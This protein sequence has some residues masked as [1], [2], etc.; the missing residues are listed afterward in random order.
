M[1]VFGL[2]IAPDY[3][4]EWIIGSATLWVFCFTLYIFIYAPVLWNPE[5]E[6]QVT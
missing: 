4:I 6:E 3:S 5:L 2:V 1:R